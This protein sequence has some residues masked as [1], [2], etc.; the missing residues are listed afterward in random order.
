M[1]AGDRGESNRCGT[2]NCHNVAWLHSSVAETVHRDRHRLNECAVGPVHVVFQFEE[3][4]GSARHVFRETAAGVFHEVKAVAVL[5]V[6]AVAAVE[7]GTT[8][9]DGVD[10]D[11][12]ADLQVVVAVRQLNDLSC[13]LVTRRYVLCFLTTRGHVEVRAADACLTNADHGRSIKHLGQRN[14][15]RVVGARSIIESSSHRVCHV[16]ASDPLGS[17]LAGLD[18]RIRVIKTIAQPINSL[19]TAITTR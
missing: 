6:V 5:S 18:I 2:D 14:I 3:S 7:T 19:P 17:V 8:G 12:V 11:A 15:L 16:V 9:A 10:S 1:R 13:H 4:E